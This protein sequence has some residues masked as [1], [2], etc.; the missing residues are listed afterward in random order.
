[1][2]SIPAGQKKTPAGTHLIFEQIRRLD[3]KGAEFWSSRDLS[4]AFEY[5]EYRHFLSVIERAKEACQNSGQNVGDHF[6]DVLEMVAIGSKA[7]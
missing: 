1:M 2:K 5:A 6:E 7:N 3:E 4:K